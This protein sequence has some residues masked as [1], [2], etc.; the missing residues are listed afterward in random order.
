MQDLSCILIVFAII[1]FMPF[2]S[3]LSSFKD[4]T[5]WQYLPR[6]FT[7][8][9][10]CYPRFT[11]KRPRSFLYSHMCGNFFRDSFKFSFCIL[12]FVL[13]RSFV[14][15]DTIRGRIKGWEILEKSFVPHNPFATRGRRCVPCLT[16]Q[17]VLLIFKSHFPPLQ[18]IQKRSFY[19]KNNEN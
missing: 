7:Q 12:F 9:S 17:K 5:R 4:K 1:F 2:E 18:L 10:S 16:S 15:S 19:F 8:N 6:A 14:S 13:F 3:S 11:A